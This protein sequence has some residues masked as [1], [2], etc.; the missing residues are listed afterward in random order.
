MPGP[1]GTEEELRLEV[2]ELT[3]LLREDSDFAD[4]RDLLAARGLRASDVLLAGFISGED[5]SQYGVLIAADLQC[6]QFEINSAR[7][8][9][10]WETIEDVGVLANDFAAVAI[11]MAMRRAGHLT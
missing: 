10:L 4:L 3:D 5:N 9:I 6:I 2:E 8:L 11:G 1:Y 7:R